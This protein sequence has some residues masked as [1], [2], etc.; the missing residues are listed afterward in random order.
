MS[1][2]VPTDELL[3]AC[4]G[5]HGMSTTEMLEK[6]SM[7][8]SSMATRLSRL[9]AQGKLTMVQRFSGGAPRYYSDPAFAKAAKQL[10]GMLAAG[11]PSQNAK[12]HQQAEV[13]VPDD[14][15]VTIIGRAGSDS[16]IDRMAGLAPRD[17]LI[18]RPGSMDFKSVQSLSPFHK[19]AAR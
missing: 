2:F 9:C 6:F 14:V 11:K 13:I 5:A 15:K 8:R 7:G 16:R 10:N 1:A 3:K 18:A 4:R 12:A 19:G 17:T